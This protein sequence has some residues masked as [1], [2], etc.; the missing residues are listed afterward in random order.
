MNEELIHLV[1]EHNGLPHAELPINVAG[2]WGSY[3][4]LPTS[5]DEARVAAMK[6]RDSCHGCGNSPCSM[7]KQGCPLGELRGIQR[8][9]E[10]LRQDRDLEALQEFFFGSPF[11]AAYAACEGPCVVSCNQN[12]MYTGVVT[13]MLE[14]YFGML[15]RKL[16]Y[17]GKFQIPSLPKSNGKKIAII[18][19]GL[20][21]MQAAWELLKK[22]HHPTIYDKNPLPGGLALDGIPPMHLI[23]VTYEQAET[24]THAM[25]LYKDI[26]EDA[27]ATFRF[28]AEVGSRELSLSNKG[29][30]TLIGREE[31]SGVIFATGAR[32]TNS[33]A[34]LESTD[35]VLDPLELLKTGIFS[36]YD[37]GN[38]P[39]PVEPNHRVAVIGAGYTARD[40]ASM[41][42]RLGANVTV[43]IRKPEIGEES[44]GWFEKPDPRTEMSRLAQAEDIELQWDT[45]VDSVQGQTANLMTPEGETKGGR[46]FD[47]IVPA[48]GFKSLGLEL[49]DLLCAE[50]N[51]PK[52][53]EVAGDLDPNSI[54][55]LP[56]AARSGADAAHRIMETLAT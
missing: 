3:Y 55:I 53:F 49:V 26:L 34:A 5:L 24:R 12:T 30:K 14:Y 21:G 25:T 9:Y 8:V 51:R 6:E 40:C 7:A 28:L 22:G 44:H 43:L 31:F 33:V 23:P 52:V 35:I 54:Q 20:A 39:C 37:M 48:T 32:K 45:V 2:F 19:A 16:F 4:K 10:L 50:N 1:R 18:G 46:N 15:L 29:D 38:E 11:V 42:R 17:E 27:G 47:F 41:A 13:P 36:F 56:G